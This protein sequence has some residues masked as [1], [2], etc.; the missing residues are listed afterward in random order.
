MGEA[1]T[2][3]E[4]RDRDGG[5]GGPSGAS[6]A[7][8]SLTQNRGAGGGRLDAFDQWVQRR[9]WAPRLIP[10][11]VYVSFIMVVSWVQET[12]PVLYPVVYIAQCAAVV[13]LLWRYRKQ[14]PELTVTFHWLAVV[15]GVAVAVVWIWLRFVTL[16]TFPQT[17]GP[18]ESQPMFDQMGLA[19]GW[20]AMGLRLIGM[21]V[22]VPLCEELCMRSLLLRSLHRPR[23]TAMGMA[24]LMEDIP[25]IGDW[26]VTTRFGDHASKLPSVF[27]TE[28]MRTPLGKLSVFGVFT[29]TLIFAIHHLPADWAGCVACGVA[30]CLLLAATKRH[31]LGPVIWAHGITNALLWAY[32]VYM[33]SIGTPDWQF[34]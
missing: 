13:W 21:S 9:F 32:T 7:G 34:L 12:A 22:V 3:T 10:Y 23:E 5:P 24:Q 2:Q 29:S 28:F 30:Y 8:T 1:L 4:S 15:V 6:S 14:L 11:A 27:R 18:V 25:V 31:G 19:V 33:Y 20:V 26:L 16:E 17:I